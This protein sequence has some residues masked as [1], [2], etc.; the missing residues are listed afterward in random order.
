MAGR[1]SQETKSVWVAKEVPILK[2]PLNLAS[3]GQG[4]PSQM[5]RSRPGS[6]EVVG[7]LNASQAL[8][9]FLVVALV[10]VYTWSFRMRVSVSCVFT[11]EARRLEGTHTAYGEAKLTSTPALAHRGLLTKL[12]PG[13]AHI[14]SRATLVSGDQLRCVCPE[15]GGGHRSPPSR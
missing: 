11:G 12:Q 7:L 10:G 1:V 5:G 6:A 15:I 9:I 8:G 14:G 3:T 4:V 2:P 13:L